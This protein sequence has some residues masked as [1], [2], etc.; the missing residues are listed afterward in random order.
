MI[1]VPTPKRTRPL[2]KDYGIHTG[3]EG[4]MEWAWVDAQMAQSRNY[5]IVTAAPDG[6][7]H[8]KPVWGV[9]VDGH[10][11]F[12]SGPQTRT[13]RNLAVN[14]RASVHLES[15][16]DVVILDGTIEPVT[17]SDPAL[18]QRLNDAYKAKYNMPILEGDS[19]GPLYMLRHQT[20]LAWLE[21]DFPKTATR[22][23]FE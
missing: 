7:P 22:W 20:V 11:Y 10:L 1:N 21:K 14:S 5:W 15:G 18:K 6:T 19:S 12:G 4:L 17:V 2:V 3:E 13:A 9:W 8:A 23:V 16:D